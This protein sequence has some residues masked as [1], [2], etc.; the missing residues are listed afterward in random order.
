[1]MMKIKQI[2]KVFLICFIYL[3][4]GIVFT[5]PLINNLNS[6][7]PNNLYKWEAYNHEWGDHLQVVAGF[8]SEKSI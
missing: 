1:M 3:I 2:L 5:Y 7:I 8:R 4:L 6:K